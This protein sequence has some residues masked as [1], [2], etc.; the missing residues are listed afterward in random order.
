MRA[1][2]SGHLAPPPQTRIA[3][4]IYDTSQ[5]R[6]IIPKQ[7]KGRT[8]A[9]GRVAR[10]TPLAPH[11][12]LPWTVRERGVLVPDLAKI[13]DLVPPCEQRSGD[14][15]HWRVAPS[16]SSQTIREGN[17]ISK[18]EVKKADLVVEPAERFQVIEESGI[19][20]P[21]PKL[22]ISNLKVAPDWVV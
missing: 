9:V 8:K 16:L 1:S 10:T 5:S 19:G 22:K 12:L 20:G 13:V 4:I 11:V 7:G 15:V 21:A 6:D 2:Q 3:V 18:S 14:R 17:K